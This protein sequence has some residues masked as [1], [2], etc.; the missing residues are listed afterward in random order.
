MNL[1]VKVIPKA[2][3]NKIT[4]IDNYTYHIHTTAPPDKDKANQSIIKILSQEL[5]I[6]KSKFTIIKGGKARHKII[7]TNP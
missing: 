2:K 3:F 6:P 4:K 7:Q 5:K 1:N